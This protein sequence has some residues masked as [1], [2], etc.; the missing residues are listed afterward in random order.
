M[1]TRQMLRDFLLDFCK[2]NNALKKG[3][4]ENFIWIL[5]KDLFE[6]K[7]FKLKKSKF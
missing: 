4:Q 7:N 5:S 6:N 1:A 2:R 3:K